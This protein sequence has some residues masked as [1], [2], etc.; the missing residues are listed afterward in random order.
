[1]CSLP[2]AALVSASVATPLKADGGDGES[3]GTVLDEVTAN[4]RLWQASEEAAY[5]RGSSTIMVCTPAA[6]EMTVMTQV[7]P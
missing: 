7:G 5:E 1:L 4:M 3:D 2:S 6:E